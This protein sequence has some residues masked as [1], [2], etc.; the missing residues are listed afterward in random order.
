M[1]SKFDLLPPVF[2]VKDKKTNSKFRILLIPRDV[3]CRHYARE[4]KEF[5]NSIHKVMA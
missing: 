5:Y 3:E 2:W 4:I 1:Q